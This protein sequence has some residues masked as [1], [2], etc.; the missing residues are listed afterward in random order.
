MRVHRREAHR[1]TGTDVAA[2]VTAVGQQHVE[3]DAGAGIDHEQVTLRLQAARAQHS[4][5]SIDSK[6]VGCAI[7]QAHT[8]HFGCGDE[9]AC[10]PTGARQ[11]GFDESVVGTHA[12][13]TER[14]DFGAVGGDA[15]EGRRQ[16]RNRTSGF[17]PGTTVDKRDEFGAGVANIEREEH[18]RNE[19]SRGRAQESGRF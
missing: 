12:A 10:R 19:Q 15:G 1:E 16:L 5:Q 17:Q 11:Q 7:G 13:P 18:G 2:D 4:G 3:R 6:G 8:A 14:S 9:A